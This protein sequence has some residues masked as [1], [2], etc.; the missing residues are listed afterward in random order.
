MSNAEIEKLVLENQ[1]LV[2]PL[3]RHYC[4]D[5][6]GCEYEDLI[7][8]GL[9]GLTKAAQ[10][11]DPKSGKA[12]H[13]YAIPRIKGGI[14]DAVQKYKDLPSSLSPPENKESS[15]DS[16]TP[17]SLPADREYDADYPILQQEQKVLLDKAIAILTP[18]EQ[19]I[20]RLTRNNLSQEGIART[21]NLDK[22]TVCH[23]LQRAT[24]KLRSFLANV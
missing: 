10:G 6:I 7:Q 1:T 22:T 19:Q 8:C 20:V 13:L 21:L 3:A 14:L 2:L 9:I 4:S 5:T 23:T 18:R 12:F 17:D 16:N 24:H 11:F 15:E